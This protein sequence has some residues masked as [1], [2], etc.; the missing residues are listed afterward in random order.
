MTLGMRKVIVA[1]VVVAILILAN[2]LV[3]AHWLDDIGLIP[4][5]QTVRDRYL[6]GTAM[7]IIMALLLLIVPQ[8]RVLIIG[9]GAQ[10]RCRVCD[11]VLGRPGRYCP[12]CGS[13]V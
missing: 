5:A 1:A 10:S 12:T 2:F 8:S 9:R 13:V 7:T 4:W 6:T 3:L 11:G